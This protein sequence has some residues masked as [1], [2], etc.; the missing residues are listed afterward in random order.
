MSKDFK[1]LLFKRQPM[2]TAEVFAFLA[3]KRELRAKRKH[4]L[5]LSMFFFNYSASFK[6]E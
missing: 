6:I 2:T 3:V 5:L 4:R 1:D